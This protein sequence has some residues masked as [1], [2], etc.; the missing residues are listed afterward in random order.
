MRTGKF[1]YFAVGVFVIAMVAALVVSI[2]VLTGR[3]GATDSYFTVYR[4]VT[5]IKFGTQVLY[6]G[7]PV[8]QVEQVTPQPEQ[9]RMRFRVD[10]TV[11]EGWRIPDDSIAEVAAPGLLSA[12]TVSIRAGSSASA[13]KP[14]AQVAGQERSDIFAVVSSVASDFGDL[15]ATS[16]KP[17]LANLNR[18]AQVFAGLMETEAPK[19]TGDLAI[20]TGDLAA[21][22]PR[23]VG[24]AEKVANNLIGISE[25]VRQLLQ[26]AKGGTLNDRIYGILGNVD[27]ATAGFSQLAR[28]LQDTRLNA[29]RLLGDLGGIAREMNTMVGDNRLDLEQTVIDLRYVLESVSRHVDAINQ[30][31]EGASRNMYEFSRQIRNNPGVLIGGRPPDDAAAGK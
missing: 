29:D 22:L 31:L 12:I 30:N 5:G 20:V 25:E 14:G 27:S 21:R 8:G 17:L 2:S 9:G 3:T 1:S 23:I 7:Y 19:M 26:P 18:V 10:F 6:E 13:L 24:D 16:L 15:S 28:E 4:N 11:R